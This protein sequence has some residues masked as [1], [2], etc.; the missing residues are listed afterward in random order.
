ML[1]KLVVF[2][3]LFILLCIV[4]YAG[5][6]YHSTK[7]Y[8]NVVAVPHGVVNENEKQFSWK[9]VDTLQVTELSHESNV[10]PDNSNG[11]LELCP[12][13]PPEL[14]GPLHV[15]FNSKR[16]LEEVKEQVGSSLQAGGRYKPPDCI[17]QQK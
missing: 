16:T 5:V 4:F 11:P 3:S 13:T 7:V 15:E 2:L 12:E 10:T 14:L 9:L 17:S 1:I 6:L 8:R